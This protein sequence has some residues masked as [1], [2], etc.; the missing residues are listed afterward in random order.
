MPG[1]LR[2]DPPIP[3][4]TPLGDAKAMIYVDRGVDNYGEWVCFLLKDGTCWTFTDPDIRLWQVPTEGRF[5]I[6]P[7]DEQRKQGFV[8]LNERLNKRQDC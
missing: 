3:I 2:L 4:A 8:S 1:V 6:A 5:E 7:F